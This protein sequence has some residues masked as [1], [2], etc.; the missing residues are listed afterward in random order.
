MVNPGVFD[1]VLADASISTRCSTLRTGRRSQLRLPQRYQD[2]ALD[3]ASPQSYFVPTRN[4]Q[5]D[6]NPINHLTKPMGQVPEAEHF[7]LQSDIRGGLC[8]EPHLGMPNFSGSNPAI[9]VGDLGL[10]GDHTSLRQAITILLLEAAAALLV[11]PAAPA[12]RYTP[13]GIP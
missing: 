13:E 1:R 6:S 3:I 12:T 7:S 11:F 9:L 4:A 10:I 5:C 2:V 8:C